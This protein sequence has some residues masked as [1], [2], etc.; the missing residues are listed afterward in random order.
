MARVPFLALLSFRSASES[1]RMSLTYE[2]SPLFR[3]ISQGAVKTETSSEFPP[4]VLLTQWA[5]ESGW[6]SK[7]TG[8]FN[9]WG[10]IRNPES[11]P[12]KFCPTHEEVTLEQLAGFRAD[13]RASITAK[14]PLGNGRYRVSTSRWFA[15]YASLEESLADY[16]STFINSPQRYKAA[17]RQYLVDKDAEALLIGICKAGYATAAD[18]QAELLAISRQENIQHAIEMARQDLQDTIT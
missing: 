18:Y 11:G 10:K 4:R 2:T 16:V 1:I 3:E 5:C 8:D 17:W 12:A 6:G 13:E 14:V 9:Y 15:S 7:I